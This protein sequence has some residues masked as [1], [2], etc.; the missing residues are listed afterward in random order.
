MEDGSTQY[1]F[2]LYLLF[3]LGFGMGVG[4][5]VRA[6]GGSEWGRGVT[7]VWAVR[8]IE[9]MGGVGVVGGGGWRVVEGV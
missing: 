4:W 1:H 8:M 9:G 5:G 3:L 6:T 2:L 7:V